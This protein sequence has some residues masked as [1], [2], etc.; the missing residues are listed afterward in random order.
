VTLISVRDFM[1]GLFSNPYFLLAVTMTFWGGNAIA[2]RLAADEMT[3][4]SLTFARWVGACLICYVAARARIHNDFAELRAAWKPIFVL[5]SIGFAGFNLTYYWALN[6]TT[7]INVAIVQ[8]V[9]PVFIIALNFAIFGQT[10]RWLQIVGVAITVVGAIVVVGRGE[11][12]L[13]LALDFNRGDLI[14]VGALLLYACYAVGLRRKPTLHWV[15]L[16]FGMSLAALVTVTPFFAI[17]LIVGEPRWPGL[18][19]WLVIGYVCI[20]PSL[21][22]QLFFLRSV[23]LVGANRAGAFINLTPILGSCMAIAFLGEQLHVYH[24]VALGLVFAGLAVVEKFAR[25]DA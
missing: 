24:V 12:E 14:M 16:L 20:F 19:G 17:E 21:L 1:R 4:I 6:Y 23:E 11:I 25:K 2:G 8:A 10:L 15:T 9:I 5:G 18:V 7:A 22:A 3:P 13:L